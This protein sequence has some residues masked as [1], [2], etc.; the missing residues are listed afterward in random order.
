MK[1]TILL[2]LMSICITCGFSIS[3]AEAAKG[4]KKKGREH[5]HAGVVVGVDHKTGH[6][7]IRTHHRGTKKKNVANAGRGRD[8]R[9]RVSNTSQFFHVTKKLKQK[10][11]FAMLHGG[12][13]VSLAAHND[14]A[15]DVIIHGKIKK[16]IQGKKTGIKR[17][18]KRKFF[19]KK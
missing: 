9:F 14:H 17:V 13:H 10:V 19:K 2:A 18:I 5:R 7:T 15:D 12:E 8:M 1:K 3:A 4:V 6:F 11:S 16:R